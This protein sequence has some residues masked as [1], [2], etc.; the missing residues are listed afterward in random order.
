MSNVIS[1]AS[2]PRAEAIDPRIL[3]E[4]ADWLM[5][6]SAGAPA[7]DHRACERWSQRSPEHARAWARAQLLL[8]KLG[9][10]PPTLAMPA[11]NRAP[12]AG[13]RAA[14]LRLAAILALAPASWGAW[15]VMDA[16]QWTADYR[17][18]VGE[19]QALQLADG[20]SITLN[21]ASAI[22]V[23]FSATQ[24][25]IRL[26]AGEILIQT[27]KEKLA[28]YRPFSVNTIEGRMEALGTRFSVRQDNESTHLAVLEGAVRITPKNGGAA[29][30]QVILA[31]QQVSFSAH[32]LADIS[33]AD[34]AVVAWAQG[35]LVADKMRLADFAAE[36]SRYRSGIVRVDP[37]V[38]EVRVSGAFPV[39]DTDKA[40]AMLVSTYQIDAM[41]RLRGHWIT[42]VA[43]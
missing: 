41:T 28:A 33:A 39:G 2:R 25:V 19:Q 10:L 3:D 40:L 18:A 27:A 5:Q 15:R 1:A 14:V 7:E 4:A 6:L 37:A 24:R 16:Q 13:R 21:T 36:L 38:A 32:K 43:R 20:S 12:H 17:T 23:Q 42:L 29:A 34:H 8:N 11:L 31:G 26:R 9:G 22:D 30:E 35:M